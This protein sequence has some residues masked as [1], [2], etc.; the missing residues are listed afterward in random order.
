M[1][2]IYVTITIYVCHITVNL[3]NYDHMQQNYFNRNETRTKLTTCTF[4]PGLNYALQNNLL[5]PEE[6]KKRKKEKKEYFLVDNEKVEQYP[7][8][9][10]CLQF[11][12][13]CINK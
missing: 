13:T 11:N 10:A 3:I 1:G 8:Q 12:N 6:K 4:L 7:Q 9:H 2:R 5:F